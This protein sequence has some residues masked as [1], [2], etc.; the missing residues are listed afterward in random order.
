MRAKERSDSV[1]EGDVLRELRSGARIDDGSL[2]VEVWNGVVTL[3]GTLDSW[4]K[5]RAAQDAAHRVPGVHQVANEI[6]VRLPEPFGGADSEVD[7]AVRD[8]LLWQAAV[9]D[10]CITFTVSEGWVTLE[11]EVERKAQRDAADAAIRHLACVRGVTTNI[12]V[13]PGRVFAG[14]VR[15]AIAS[16]LEGWAERE[17]SR[18]RIQVDDDVVTLSGTVH[19]GEERQAVLGAANAIRGVRSVD[20]RL[21]IGSRVDGD[22][23]RPRLRKPA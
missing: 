23:E 1:V 7:S 14:D 3:S 5:R 9:P 15:S 18:I 16:A 11:G 10:G 19:S 20:D 22:A 17:A 6:V 21:Q 13:M 2:E 12:K 4:A 8:A